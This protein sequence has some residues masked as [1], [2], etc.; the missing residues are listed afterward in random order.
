METLKSSIIAMGA[1]ISLDLTSC[2]PVLYS[3]TGQNVPLFHQKGE[4][5]LSYG[6]STAYNF[7]AWDDM[8]LGVNAQAAVA[9]DSAVALIGGFYWLQE[10]DVWS[11]SGRYFDL[12]AGLF[13][14]NPRG[15]FVGEIF[16]GA[17]LGS[18]KNSSETDEG[19]EYFNTRFYKLF[20]QP[21]LG[22]STKHIELAFTPRIALVNVKVKTNYEYFERVKAKVVYEPGVSFRAGGDQIKFQYQ[23]NYSTLLSGETDYFSVYN[24]YMSFGVSFLISGW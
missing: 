9:V 16:M 14:Y 3:T 21:S 17:G 10:E 13:K 24:L 4:V 7:N 5:A 22:M 8:S 18:I 11:G 23:L 12:G 6:I 19:K 2:S 1:F 15:H 20:L